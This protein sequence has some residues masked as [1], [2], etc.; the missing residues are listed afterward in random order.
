MFGGD[1]TERK[2]R[3]QRR[4]QPPKTW[5]IPRLVS[6]SF[7]AVYVRDGFPRVTGLPGQALP[8]SFSFPAD[9]VRPR[10]PFSPPSSSRF[11]SPPLEMWLNKGGKRGAW[12]SRVMAEG[13]KTVISWVAQ[14]GELGDT[15]TEQPPTWI[16]PPTTSRLRNSE[17]RSGAPSLRA[18]SVACVR[19]NWK[20][21]SWRAEC[22]GSR[23]LTASTHLLVSAWGTAG[24][25]GRARARAWADTRPPSGFARLS[26]D[27]ASSSF[28][29]GSDAVKVDGL[30][31]PVLDN[32]ER[33]HA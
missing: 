26:A 18:S 25:N 32:R 9:L 19:H 4:K 22:V 7:P 1:S 21:I 16:P 6:S 14:R 5:S 28:I 8:A 13:A 29:L 24:G 11:H 31:R 2:H 23:K 17:L 10:G 15:M 3:P 20:V 27:A 33:R 12:E 30:V